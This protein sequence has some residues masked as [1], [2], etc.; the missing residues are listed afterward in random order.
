LKILDWHQKK[1]SGSQKKGK[2]PAVAPGTLTLADLLTKTQ[3]HIDEF[4]FDLA[5]K[6]C[7]RVLKVSPN[8]LQA[9]ELMGGILL[10]FGEIDQA[11]KV[12]YFSF[13]N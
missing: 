4:Q 8:N 7:A 13:M 1:M 11:I 3:N 9:L 2:K 5:R 6:T 12:F 10:E